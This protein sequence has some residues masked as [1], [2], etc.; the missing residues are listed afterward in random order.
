MC[1]QEE[2]G[3]SCA[4]LCEVLELGTPRPTAGQVLRL[5]QASVAVQC[6][7]QG[8]GH[9]PGLL[10]VISY[11]DKCLLVLC[12]EHTPIALGAQQH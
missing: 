3:R 12:G 8:S 2:N 7:L 4:K 9:R 6:G 11:L 5:H 1:Q 10:K